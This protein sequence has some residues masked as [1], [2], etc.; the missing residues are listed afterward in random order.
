[1]QIVETKIL[2]A[3]THGVYSPGQRLYLALE[4]GTRFDQALLSINIDEFA[5]GDRYIELVRVWVRV[6]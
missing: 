3:F 6:L 4:L 5:T 2:T 1:M